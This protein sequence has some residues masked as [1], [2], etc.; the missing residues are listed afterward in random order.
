LLVS[1][2]KN[3]PEVSASNYT[4]GRN[5]FSSYICASENTTFYKSVALYTEQSEGVLEEYRNQGLY[6]KSET[7][8]EPRLLYADFDHGLNVYFN[9]LYFIDTGHQ[10]LEYDLT[11]G[12]TA[13]IAGDKNQ[14]TVTECLIID[15]TLFYIAGDPVSEECFLTAYDLIS[16]ETAVIAENVHW[17]RLN[18]YQEHIQFWDLDGNVKVYL[19]DSGETLDYGSFNMDEVF[20]ILDDGTVVGHIGPMFVRCDLEGKNISSLF[21]M[22][23]VHNVIVTQNDLFVSTLEETGSQLFHFSFSENEMKKIA[24]T[25]FPL[26]G[27]TDSY[28]FCGTGTGQGDIERITI[29]SGKADVLDDNTHRGAVSY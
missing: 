12:L 15:D 13:V 25:S 21:S 10:L 27:Y 17:E 24:N 16:K 18:H 23:Q 28:I 19:P 7:N 6:A 14:Q 8:Q 22:E 1:C 11:T 5:P 4:L 20:Q 26:V 3:E 29:S 2:A 9:R